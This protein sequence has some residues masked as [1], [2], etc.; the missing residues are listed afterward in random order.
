MS[1]RIIT[2]IYLESDKEAKP[3]LLLQ[4]SF[5]ECK[6]SPK[7]RTIGAAATKGS[8]ASSSVR[9][10]TMLTHCVTMYRRL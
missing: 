5:L 9:P 10:K 8:S 7:R 2:S 3:G 4:Y 6:S 1:S